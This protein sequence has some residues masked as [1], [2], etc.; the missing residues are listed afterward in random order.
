MK[1]AIRVLLGL[2]L[3]VSLGSYSYAD[4]IYNISWNGPYGAGFGT[5][6]VANTTI[7]N[8]QLITGFDVTQAGLT[9][10]LL[11]VG[12]YGDNDNL[13]Y[14]AA[15]VWVDQAGIAFSDGTY[16]YNIYDDFL[17]NLQPS[18]RECISSATACLNANTDGLDLES[19]SMTPSVPTPEPSSLTLLV[20]AL[21]VLIAATIFPTR[22]LRASNKN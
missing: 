5:I 2:A 9:L 13:V 20:S 12:A 22:R 8:I 1:L 10:D 21:L 14:P 11:P 4:D 16:D 15:R 19:F 7:P 17:S 6:T 3:L 18:Y